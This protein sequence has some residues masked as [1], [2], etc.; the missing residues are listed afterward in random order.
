MPGAVTDPERSIECL[1]V[2]CFDTSGQFKRHTIRR[3]KPLAN[4]ILIDI[5]Y[6]GICHSD[7]HQG[8]A[9]WPIN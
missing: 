2:A 3:K 5:E 8:R 6:A 7:V 9:E 1:A 4:D